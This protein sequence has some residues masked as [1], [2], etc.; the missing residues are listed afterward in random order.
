[1]PSVRVKSSD[2]PAGGEGRSYVLSGY[3]DFR[4]RA[5]LNR[6]RQDCP[7]PGFELVVAFRAAR[8]FPG[9]RLGDDFLQDQAHLPV[10]GLGGLRRGGGCFDQIA[11]DQD[12]KGAGDQGENDA[13]E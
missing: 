5:R 2:D 3:S 8:G 13:I 10:S 4:L 12:P 9:D 1:M 7:K 11:E 6:A